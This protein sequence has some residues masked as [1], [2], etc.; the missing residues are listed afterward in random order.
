VPAARWAPRAI[1]GLVGPARLPQDHV[2]RVNAAVARGLQRRDAQERLQELGFDIAGGK[3]AQFG[4]WI[5]AE[6]AKWAKVVKESGA[7]PE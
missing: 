5:V 3:P 1:N 7:K 6:T 4:S 2:R